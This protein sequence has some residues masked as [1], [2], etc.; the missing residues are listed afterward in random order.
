M[1][2]QV[3]I[4]V[5][6]LV[7]WYPV[8]VGI[9]QK[10]AGYV[11]AVD[12]V[13]FSIKRSETLGLVGESGCGKTTTARCMLRLTEPTKGRIFFEGK[14]IMKFDRESMRKLRPRMQVIFQD[15]YSSLNP[16]LTVKEIIGEALTFHGIARG[17][18]LED[19]VGELL[20][21]VGLSPQHIKRFP[22]EFSGGQRQRI[23]IARALATNPDLIVCDEPV[24]ALDVSIQSQIL[25]LLE[26]LQE[27]L[28]VS[29]LFIAHGLNVV[30]HISHRVGVMYLGKLVEIADSEEIYKNPLHPYT[31]ALIS[32]IPI[33]DP[34]RKREKI[35]LEGDVPSPINPPEGCRFWTRCRYVM[36]ICRHEE[37]ELLE[38]APGHKVA[39]HLYKC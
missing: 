31:Q 15:P 19:R 33:P 32:A 12:G 25:N 20:K 2:E 38:S 8:K 37:P 23:G 34:K 4:E 22:H 7:K 10:V 13:S 16:R 6:D 1:K 17:R 27:R 9:L 35:L 28:G 36:D 29:Y 30:K 39:C 3:V 14:D 26:D 21:M 18:E 11:K 24:S 5:Q